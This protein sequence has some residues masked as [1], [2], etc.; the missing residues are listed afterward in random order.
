MLPYLCGPNSKFHTY[1]TIRL[2]PQRGLLVTPVVAF[3]D[4][5]FSPRPN[6][7]EVSA[8][9]YA[10][11]ELFISRKSH[12]CLD[13]FSG[14]SGFMHFFHYDDLESGNSYHIWGLTALLAVLVSTLALRKKPEFDIFYDIADP[15]P[16]FKK[17]LH[18]KISKL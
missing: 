3:I 17:A 10:P 6:P 13:V 16:F 7:A 9:F 11:L 15:L 18:Q 2:S 1:P 8:I 4:E 14:Q 5:S 12:R